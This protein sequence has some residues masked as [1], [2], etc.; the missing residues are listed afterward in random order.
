MMVERPHMANASTPPP[1]GQ[2]A[3]RPEE[4]DALGPEVHALIERAALVAD[5]HALLHLAPLECAAVL[6]GAT[7]RALEQ[8]RA[9]LE[10][11]VGRAAAVAIFAR[12]AE[13][14]AFTPPA[15][16][17]AP[18]ARA[19]RDPE[20]LLLAAQG[21]PD[22]LALLVSAAAES[23]AIAF[24]VHPHVVL[25]ARVLAAQRGLSPNSPPDP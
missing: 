21:R 16:Q 20:A 9:A 17:P 1:G 25:S 15:R 11:P 8:A 13:G 5:G 2:H 18:A 23:A 3:R 12:A 19:P 14:R 22:G 7:P 10:S 6:L 4:V 24:G